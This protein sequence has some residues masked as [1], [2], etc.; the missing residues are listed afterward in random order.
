M[1]NLSTSTKLDRDE[2]IKRAAAFF[3]PTGYG[4]EVAEETAG[5]VSFKGGGGGVEV[6]ANVD[7]EKTTVDLTSQEWDYQVKE[8]LGKIK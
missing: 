7:G 8:F 5:Y 1:L 6:I 4:L 3:G 2:V